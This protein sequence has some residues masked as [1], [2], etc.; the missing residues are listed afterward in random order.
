MTFTTPCARPEN[1]PN[2]WFI[3]KD[4]R[5]YVDEPVFTKDEIEV[6]VDAAI[7]ADQDVAVA[8]QTAT[9]QRLT[10]NLLLR[11]HAKDKCHVDCYLR[12]TC[13]SIAL[14]NPSPATH[15]TWGG[16]YS[17]ELRQIRQLR[18]ARARASQD[19]DVPDSE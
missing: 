2:D 13:L 9:D 7:D 18:D 16:Y 10:E 11:R 12:T 5:Q 15:G 4:G 1:D 6:I 3:E 19:A 14:A 8:L 17:E